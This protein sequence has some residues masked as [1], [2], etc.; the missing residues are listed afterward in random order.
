MPDLELS[1]L[2]Q[3]GSELEARPNERPWLLLCK[4][5]QGQWILIGKPTLDV[6]EAASVTHYWLGWFLLYL[7]EKQA[8]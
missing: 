2:E 7:R 6:G 3:I 5:P 8:Q 4:N 1:T